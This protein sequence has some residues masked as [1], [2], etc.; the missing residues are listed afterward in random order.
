MYISYTPVGLDTING[1]QP[2]YLLPIVPLVCL[3]VP[4]IRA[5][6]RDR[7]ASPIVLF[8]SAEIALCALVLWNSFVV[9]F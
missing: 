9:W 5:L 4:N 2:R 7:G 6:Q 1:V 3:L 8:L